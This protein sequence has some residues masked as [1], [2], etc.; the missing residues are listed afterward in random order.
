[1]PINKLNFQQIQ[2]ELMPWAGIQIQT[3]QDTESKI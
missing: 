2:K 3:K 1:M